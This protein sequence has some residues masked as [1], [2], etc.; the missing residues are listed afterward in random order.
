MS[1]RLSPEKL[2]ELAST[3]V[4]RVARL[5]KELSQFEKEQGEKGEKLRDLFEVMREEAGKT[6]IY[7]VE[8]PELGMFIKYA[9]L[10]YNETKAIV[11]AA[12]NRQQEAGNE[13]VFAM[14]QK[15]N[16]GVNVKEML[17]TIDP[18][19]LAAISVRMFVK[20]PL[21]KEKSGQESPSS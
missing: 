18:E 7:V 21:P 9:R 20:S 1:F 2:A 16:P 11:K 6:H 19:V 13:I 17:P 4:E 10:T 12:G 8:V 14:I 5:T 3:E 15:G